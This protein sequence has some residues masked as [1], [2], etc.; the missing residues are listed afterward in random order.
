ME[1]LNLSSIKS[2]ISLDLFDLSY[3]FIKEES[4]Q[5]SFF[6]NIF[7][8]SLIDS[9]KNIYLI[10]ITESDSIQNLIIENNNLKEKLTIS[11]F[12]N[13]KNHLSFKVEKEHTEEKKT[14]TRKLLLDRNIFNLKNIF[15]IKETVLISE[16]ENLQSNEIF[17]ENKLLISKDELIDNKII[18]RS[19]T[20]SENNLYRKITMEFQEKKINYVSDDLLDLLQI[21][22]DFNINKKTKKFILNTLCNTFFEK[23]SNLLLEK[24]N[25][26][27]IKNEY[28]RNNKL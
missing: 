15:Q 8:K 28:R 20:N 25:N 14:E 6:D 5:Q 10:N 3:S 18:L 27:E 22:F 1:N 7:I 11:S 12:W 17:T 24:I 23:K 21:K 9:N 19:N 4:N 13:M 26:I 2:I 16:M